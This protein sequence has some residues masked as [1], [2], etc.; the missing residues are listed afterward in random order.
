MER[1]SFLP[2][3]LGF[4]LPLPLMGLLYLALS[5]DE[6]PLPVPQGRFLV[7]MLTAAERQ[8]LRT[9]GQECQTDADCEP[10]LRCTYDREGRRSCVDSACGTNR[11]C[12]RDHV[13]RTQRAPNGKDLMRACARVGVRKE[14]ELCDN[15]PVIPEEGCERHLLCSGFCGR[16]CRLNEPSSCPEGFNCRQDDDGPVCV[17]SCEGRSCPEGQRCITGLAGGIGSI[18]MKVYG[19]DCEL[20]PCPQGLRCIQTP[21]PSAPGKIWME[22]ARSCGDTP[23]PDGTVCSFYQCRTACDLQGPPV[24][25][26]GFACRRH[27][28]GQPWACMPSSRSE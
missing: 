16:P 25:G 28:P 7:P 19:Q 20:N 27:D 4:L 10:R 11:D 2:A 22:C 5:G 9:Y 17:P 26:P 14:G 23:C 21:S 13:C 8:S 12:P 18:C 24:C 15:F 3:L 6:V 1:R